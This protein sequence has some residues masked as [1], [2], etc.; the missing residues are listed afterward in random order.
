MQP[1][2]NQ[3]KKV[4]QGLRMKPMDQF[5]RFQKEY[6]HRCIFKAMGFTTQELSLPRIAVVN[7]WS[8]QSPGNVHLRALSDAVKAG[9]RMAGGMPFEINVI[10]PCIVFSGTL[11]DVSY[12][13][14]QRGLR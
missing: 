5:G 13:L 10:G 9:I 2:K 1:M 11:S 12:D 14:P 7:S 6:G 8:E 4:Q 3:T